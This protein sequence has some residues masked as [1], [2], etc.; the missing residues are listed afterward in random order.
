[1]SVWLDRPGEVHCEILDVSGRRVAFVDLG[2]RGPGESR[3]PLP[4]RGRDGALLPTGI[5]LV[6]VRAGEATA[7]RKWVRVR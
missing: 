6:R 5:Y 4:S 3:F 2:T 1:M 7:V